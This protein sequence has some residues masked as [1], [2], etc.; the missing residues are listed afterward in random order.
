M[1]G[2]VP[3]FWLVNQRSGDASHVRPEKPE[4]WFYFVPSEPFVAMVIVPSVQALV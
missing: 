2:V 3:K 1:L 4:V